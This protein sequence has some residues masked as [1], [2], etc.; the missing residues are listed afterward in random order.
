MPTRKEHPIQFVRGGDWNNRNES[1]L[2]HPGDLMGKTT[3]GDVD[4]QTVKL[5]SGATS[6]VPQG[7]QAA[8]DVAYWKDRSAGL[9]THDA[10]VAEKGINS[11]AGVFPCAV[12]PG[13]YTAIK[14]GRSRNVNV[15]VDGSAFVAGDQVISDSAANGPQGT[16]V[17]AGTAAAQ[18]QY[19]GQSRGVSAGGVLAVDLMLPDFD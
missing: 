12:T 10:R 16:R 5:D 7:A 4:Y 13:Y 19:I 11:V 14:T 2:L 15:A 3:I 1:E 8:N 17:A 18:G 6:A 9:V